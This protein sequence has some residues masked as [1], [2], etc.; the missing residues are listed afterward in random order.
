MPGNEAKPTDR[1]WEVRGLGYD[2][3]AIENEARALFLQ[4][5]GTDWLYKLQGAV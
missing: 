3:A 4:T 2:H 1:S 5:Y